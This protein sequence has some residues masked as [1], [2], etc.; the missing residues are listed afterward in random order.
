MPF[1]GTASVV[2]SRAYIHPVSGRRFSQFTSWFEPGSEL[3]T[4]GWTIAWS[5]DGTVGHCRPP[6]A[7]KAEAQ[8]YADKWNMTH[9]FC[10][11]VREANRESE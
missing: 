5:G 3:K 11:I 9:E 2:E 6:F 1:C 8:A 4:L 10:A 7:T